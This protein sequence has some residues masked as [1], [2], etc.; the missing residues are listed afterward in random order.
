MTEKKADQVKNN[1]D[2]AMKTKT[3]EKKVDDTP[4]VKKEGEHIVDTKNQKTLGK[5]EDGFTRPMVE[6]DE[7]YIKVSQKLKEVQGEVTGAKTEMEILRDKALGPLKPKLS[8]L[9]AKIQGLTPLYNYQQVC[10]KI[11]LARVKSKEESC[12]YLVCVVSP[13]LY[14][15]SYGA[16]QWCFAWTEPQMKEISL[17]VGMDNIAIVERFSGGEPYISSD[18]RP[19]SKVA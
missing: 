16:D 8:K 12:L 11:E 18:S 1:T 15:K 2:T 3:P 9:Q 14:K 5:P 10:E 4:I 7:R 17:K 6:T 13:K 19:S